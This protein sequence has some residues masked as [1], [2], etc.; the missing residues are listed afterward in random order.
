ML[1]LYVARIF[2]VVVVVVISVFSSATTDTAS[3]LISCTILP[4]IDQG[5]FLD[6]SNLGGAE[7]GSSS[8][9]KFLN[10]YIALPKCK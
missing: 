8:A 2:V 9:C 10:R 1:L 7:E 6:E 4:L 3:I 5:F